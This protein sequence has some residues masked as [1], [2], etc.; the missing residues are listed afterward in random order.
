MTMKKYVLAAA[1]AAGACSLLHAQDMPMGHGTNGGSM[2]MDNGQPKLSPHLS[3]DADLTGTKI[4]VTY[5]A[6]SLRGRKMVGGKDPYGKEWRVGAD[7]ATS[8]EVSTD[9]TVNGT[10][11]P[12]GSYT[13]FVLPTAEKWT[14]IISK[15]TG[16][17]GIPYPGKQYDFARVDM[18]KAS[19]SSPQERMSI[20]FEKTTPFKTEMHVKWDKDNYFVTVQKKK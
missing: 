14:L 12:A 15:K 7:E 6:P 2:K 13:L 10:S 8:F 4:H 18:T 5:G 9:V 1:L 20:G 19:L 16:E 3:A 11:V 17:W